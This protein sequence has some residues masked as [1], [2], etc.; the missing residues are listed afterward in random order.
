MTELPDG[1]SW[2]T[3]GEVCEKPKYG[4]TTSASDIGEVKL[5]R[6]TDLTHGPITWE[7]VPFCKEPPETV[8]DYLVHPNDIFISRAGSVG[9][10]VLVKDAPYKSVFASYLI[11]IRPTKKIDAK[12]LSLFLQSP[13]YWNQVTELSSGIALANI[14]AT[15]IQSM[16]LPLPPIDE[17]HK[18]VELLEDHLSRLDAA[19]ADVRY[20]KSKSSQL[21]FAILSKVFSG[22]FFEFDMPKLSLEELAKV[23]NGDR[24]KN[25][26]NKSA[27]VKSGIPFINAGHLDNDLLNVEEMD[28]ISQE[29]YKLLAAGKVELN[30]LLFCLRGSLG[31]VAINDKY[32]EGA[33][34]SSLA[35]LRV[36]SK[37]LPKYLYYYFLSPL[38]AIEIKKHD[39]GTA[40][41][42]LS[43]AN[44]RKFEVPIPTIE[45]QKVVIDFLDSELS[46]TIQA[47][48]TFDSLFSTASAMRRSLLQ[49]AFTGQLTNEVVSV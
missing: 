10:S 21:K 8:V 17:Q 20:A 13:H 46:R 7:T 11:R 33:I 12:Y 18:I 2:A 36:N 27:R 9:V 48:Q 47:S 43:A 34:A 37:V 32:I 23:M 30:D 15:K 19:L 4:W 5:L 1:W 42:N 40:Q 24:G 6:T 49:A 14:N 31:K 38:A 22:E 41:P 35:I 25:Y 29:R 16:T 26:P 28:F 44:L 45:Q 3:I 39:N